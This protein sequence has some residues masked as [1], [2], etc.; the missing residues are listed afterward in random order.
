VSATGEALNVGLSHEEIT[1]ALLH[2]AVY[3]GFPRAVNATFAAREVFA[4]RDNSHTN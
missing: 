1:E 3:C 2:A 4:E